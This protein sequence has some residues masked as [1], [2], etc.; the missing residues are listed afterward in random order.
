MDFTLTH[1]R[2]SGIDLL[3]GNNLTD[4]EYADDIVLLSGDADEMQSLLSTFSCNI[5]M[6]GMRFAP[7]KCKMMWLQDWTTLTPSLEIGS[8]V[9]E[10]VDRITYL[11]STI[12]QRQ[13]VDL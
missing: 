8:E 3:P 11:G 1:F 9:V 4:L 2:D 7:A 12:N 5:R 10:Y 13:R 6:F